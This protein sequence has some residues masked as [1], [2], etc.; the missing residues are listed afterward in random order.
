[1]ENKRELLLDVFNNKEVSRVPVGLWWHFVSKHDEF[2]GLYDESVIQRTIDG[3]KKLFDELDPDFIKIM[4]DGFFGHPFIMEN[5]IKN[6]DD[7]RNIKSIGEDHKW[8]DKQVDMI[9][10]LVDYFDNKIMSFYNIFSPLNYIRLYL[11]NYKNQPNLFAKLFMEDPESMLKASMEISKDLITLV[12]KI[13]NETSVDGVFYS[14]QS[15]QDKSVGKEFHDKYLKPSDLKVLDHINQ[16]WDNNIIH[17]CGYGP[18]TNDLRYYKDYKAKVYNWAVNTENISLSEGKELFN[19][20]CIIGGFDNSAGAVLDIG[21]E[22]EVSDTIEDIIEEVGK[23]GII[24]GADCT[25]SEEIG[26]RRFSLVKRLAKL[27][28]KVSG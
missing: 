27:N 1:M 14:V 7:I 2:T 10:E 3:T 4:S 17:I 12:D 16:K 25:I 13:K 23:K 19:D 28:S 26:H 5:D 18:Y 6:I 11:T 21:S 20:A 8:Y 22:E 15:L 9:N 24:I